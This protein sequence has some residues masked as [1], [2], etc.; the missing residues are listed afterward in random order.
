MGAE[1]TSG[2][3]WGHT[4]VSDNAVKQAGVY[5]GAVVGSLCKQVR[6]GQWVGLEG[7]GAITSGCAYVRARVRMSK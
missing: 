2:S 6:S 5:S 4:Y 7:T 1:R 3:E